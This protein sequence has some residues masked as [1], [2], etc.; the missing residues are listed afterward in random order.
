MCRRLTSVREFFSQLDSVN[1]EEIRPLYHVLEVSGKTREDEPE[2]YGS[3]EIRKSLRM[4]LKDGYILAP[5]KGG[6]E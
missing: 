4:R 3:E 6:Y 2:P 5:W 1:V